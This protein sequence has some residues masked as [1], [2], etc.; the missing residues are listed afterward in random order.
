MLNFLLLDNKHAN[1]ILIFGVS[2]SVNKLGLLPRGFV[3]KSGLGAFRVS[4]LAMSAP[5]ALRWVRD[6]LFHHTSQ[7]QD[8]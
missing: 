2:I 6:I 5:Y 8:T 1:N 4:I 7:S 3:E